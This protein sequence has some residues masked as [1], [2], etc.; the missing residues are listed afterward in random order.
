MSE[1]N[2]HHRALNVVDLNPSLSRRGLF[3]V[4][5]VGVAPDDLTCRE[6]MSVLRRDGCWVDL[7]VYLSSG[8]PEK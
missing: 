6:R 5:Q 3:L 8:Q 1:I 7:A 2:N 4:T